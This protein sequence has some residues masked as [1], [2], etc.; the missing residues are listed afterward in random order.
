MLLHVPYINNSVQCN[1]AEHILDI[2]H[3]SFSWKGGGLP[4]IDLGMNFEG[5]NRG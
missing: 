5:A 3:L 2:I 1:Y 4:G